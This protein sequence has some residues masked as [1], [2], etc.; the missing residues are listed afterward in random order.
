MTRRSRLTYLPNR[1]TKKHRPYRMPGDTTET[2]S[3]SQR[4]QAA[5]HTSLTS[6]CPNALN[7]VCFPSAPRDVADTNN[8]VTSGVRLR[9]LQET[10][11][12]Q[13]TDVALL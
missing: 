7:G 5:S 8:C 1:V 6:L 10:A 2:V 11:P 13:D 3:Q 12:G 4:A 9:G